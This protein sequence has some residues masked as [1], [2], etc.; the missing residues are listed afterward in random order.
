MTYATD[1]NSTNQSGGFGAA[2]PRVDMLGVLI[3]PTN[4][5]RAV[6]TLDSWR[7]QGKREYVCCVSVHG[8][9]EAQSDPAF[10]EVLSRAALTTQDGM[11][12]V[13]WC[14]HAGFKETSRACGRDLLLAM[15]EIAAE[16]GHRHYFYGGAPGIPELLVANL[17]QRYP[18]L[19]VAGYRSPPFRPLT[20]EEDAA[21]LKII[22]DTNPD[23]VWIGLG[24]P[25]QDRWMSDHLGK[26]SAA[27]LLGVG[28]AFDFHA[29]AKQNAP[30]W[31]QRS[32]LEWMF[33][34]ACEP[35]RLARRYLVGNAIFVTLAARQLL[36]FKTSVA[37]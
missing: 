3:T 25:K 22:N 5:T 21:E 33:R 24:T 10:R 13:W 27:A 12:L 15:C 19:T 8:L 28:A 6:E 20:P 4:L 2:P 14:Q 31:M 30:A 1:V 37:K 11:P 32:G 9:V 26:I 16:R 17:K 35:K 7:V 34:L 29:G 23:F 18:G 36:G